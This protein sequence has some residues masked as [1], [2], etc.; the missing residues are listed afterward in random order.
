MET[1]T[2]EKKP[3]I[4]PFAIMVTLFW[5]SL[6]AYQ[7]FLS[8][9]S[10][11]LGADTVFVGTILSSY[12]FTQMLLRVPIGLASD[13]IGKRKPFVSMGFA[14][15]PAALLIFRGLSGAAAGAWVSFTVLF[16][17]YYDP[18]KAPQA[19]A[20]VM[21]FNE[22]GRMT[23]MLLGGQASTLFGDRA[24]FFLAAI[25][26][27]LALATSLFI[28]EKAVNRQASVG[29][30]EQLKVGLD[31]T[32]LIVS[33][34]ALL[35]QIIQWGATNGFTPQYAVKLGCTP[36]QLGILTSLSELGILTASIL[37]TRI[38]L[39]KWGARRCIITGAAINAAATACI[40]LFAHSIP[41]LFAFQ[42]LA[43][44]G[45]G[46]CFPLLMGLSI[47]NIPGEKRGVAMG[48][49]QSIYALGMFIGPII[50]SF[51]IK[52]FSLPVS[53]L[54]IGCSGFIT[55]ALAF[56]A[57]PKNKAAGS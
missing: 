14:D 33:G 47:Q 21:I 3:R 38:L 9:H 54:C 13:R 48:F 28:T 18:A 4:I 53:L 31:R 56:F 55:A 30:A 32:L 43:G 41:A 8:P 22:L 44:L 2:Q 6:Y 15:S 19:M 24:A 45:N 27:S 46:L 16:S 29:L 40:P 1:A 39:D 35:V 7:P 20:K 17:S 49:Y 51:L 10:Y 37:N 12:G 5:M 36:A 34:L 11:S 52:I 50:T 42:C 26:G 23:A 57:L 25:L